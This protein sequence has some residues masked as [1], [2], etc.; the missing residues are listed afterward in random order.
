M[1]ILF[2]IVSSL[3]HFQ[4]PLFMLSKDVYSTRSNSRTCSRKSAAR[5]ET[6]TA[7]TSTTRNQSPNF[8]LAF[9]LSALSTGHVA[10]CQLFLFLGL[11]VCWNNHNILSFEGIHSI[12]L[13]QAWVE[14]WMIV[15]AR[16]KSLGVTEPRS[17]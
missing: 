12:G 9:F 8:L 11:P 14:R 4:L 1:S 16:K 3:N 13:S 15:L 6:G 5:R 2:R 17:S 7:T 10:D